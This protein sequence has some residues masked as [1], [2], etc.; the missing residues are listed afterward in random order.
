M[1][2]NS[3]STAM[4]SE[5]VTRI[6]ESES[7]KSLT[8][9]RWVICSI[10]ALYVFVGVPLWFKLT[11]IY[12]APLP[13]NFINLLH[14]QG[15]I[16]VRITNEVYL[17]VL[18]GLKFPDLAEAIQVQ[19]NH[20][21]EQERVQS[22]MSVLWNA[23]VLQTS[24]EVPSDAYVLHLELAD[25]EGI[26]LDET[27]KHATLFYT[28]ES[29]KNNDLPFFATQAILDHIFATERRLLTPHKHGINSLRYSPKV[30]LSFKLLTGDGYPLDWEIAQAID[31]YFTP[32]IQEFKTFINFTIDSEIKYFAQLN[33]PEGDELTLTDA[34][35]STVM[36]FAEWD[37]SSN[38]FSYP[39]LNFVLYYPSVEQSP[40]A[41]HDNTIGSL[42]SYLIP[43]WGSVVLME[44]SIDANTVISKQSLGPLLEVFT[45]ELFKL[46]GIPTDP[47]TPQIRVDAMKKYSILEN[48][49][50]GVDSL[51]SLLKLSESLPDMSI[52]KTVLD[53]VKM[54]LSSRQSAVDK[55]N[56]Q[57]DFNGALVDS[58]SMVEHSERA[59]FDREMVQQ[60]F[61]PQE[62]KIAVYMPLIGPMTL[63]CVL[64][65]LRTLKEVRLYNKKYYE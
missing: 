40:L 51:V 64:A 4:A 31:E 55:L 20:R 36:D 38:Q 21:L 47:K 25:N 50:R 46:L 48:I 14:S 32:L 61:F 41:F 26:S 19:I 56:L 13:S 16:D 43:Q 27:Q 34:S 60:T 49:D 33:L 15:N 18:D 29:V 62:H 11:E 30:H 54:A 52:P 37:I 63:I 35:L 5:Q 12:R 9:R 1:L 10:V 22:P 65:L 17:D 59:F 6:L 45:S 2:A 53:N 39:T 3:E 23:S 28:M 24:E 8:L 7:L 58:I 57:N 42:H 44:N